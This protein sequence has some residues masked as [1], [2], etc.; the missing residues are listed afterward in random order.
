MESSLAS[1]KR[2]RNNK[3]KYNT[4]SKKI[5]I[6]VEE[7]GVKGR[8]TRSKAVEQN[9]NI[10]GDISTQRLEGMM[11]ASTEE[12]SEDQEGSPSSPFEEP[13]VESLKST[14]RQIDIEQKLTNKMD[15]L[16]QRL[17][18]LMDDDNEELAEDLEGHSSSASEKLLEDSLT[19]PSSMI[20]INLKSSTVKPILIKPKN[21]TPRTQYWVPPADDHFEL[22][23][24]GR[25]NTNA[26]ESRDPRPRD[27][28]IADLAK[29]IQPGIS[30][31]PPGDRKIKFGEDSYRSPNIYEELEDEF[32]DTFDNFEAE[33]V[34]TPEN[35]GQQKQ[36]IQL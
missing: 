25:Q 14:S 2:G 15:S 1:P 9:M 27:Q 22:M 32:E 13:L 33:S 16:P 18:G 30:I 7:S 17:E 11:T 36:S 23:V 21:V 28:M 19:S 6:T 12:I 4:N 24:V 10:K 20:N 34:F 26:G 31:S 35:A 29:D 5:K 8:V 3:N